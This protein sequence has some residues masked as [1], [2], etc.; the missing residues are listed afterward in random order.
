[1]KDDLGLVSEKEAGEGI[2]N[3]CFKAETETERMLSNFSETDWS[4]SDK[5]VIAANV[6]I[7]EEIL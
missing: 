4:I 3:I 1:M 7:H 6:Y 5:D 2:V